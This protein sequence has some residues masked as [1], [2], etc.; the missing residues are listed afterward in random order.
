M[1]RP[2][3]G[4]RGL[5]QCLF[6]APCNSWGILFV[7][8]PHPSPFLQGWLGE[9]GSLAVSA[10][11][12]PG[13][14]VE[15]FNNHLPWTPQLAGLGP[16]PRV[17]SLADPAPLWC[18]PVLSVCLGHTCGRNVEVQRGWCVVQGHRA[19]L[20]LVFLAPPCPASTGIQQH[21]VQIPPLPLLAQCRFQLSNVCLPSVLVLVRG[22]G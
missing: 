14:T 20:S 22:W 16:R 18:P 12:V 3:L 13:S 10:R 19:A 4:A 5:V 2:V 11:L 6:V 8:Q 21:W 17:L 15:V 7:S 9:F 1:L